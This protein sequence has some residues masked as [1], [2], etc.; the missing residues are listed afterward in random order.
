MNSLSET[1][2][3][4]VAVAWWDA[5]LVTDDVRAR[6]AF[7]DT[8]FTGVVE[9]LRA[10]RTNSAMPCVVLGRYAQARPGALLRAACLIAH[11]PLTAIP[12]VTVIMWVGCDGRVTVETGDALPGD[13]VLREAD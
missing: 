3:A 5:R 11:L 2:A 1:A 13:L 7:R 4:E 6:R 12:P 8:L 10:A 9:A